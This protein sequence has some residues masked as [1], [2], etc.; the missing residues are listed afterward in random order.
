MHDLRPESFLVVFA[1]SNI[2]YVC[3]LNNVVLQYNANNSV[4]YISTNTTTTVEVKLFFLPLSLSHSLGA[5]KMYCAL[6]DTH[7]TH[8]IYIHNIC[9]YTIIYWPI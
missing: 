7:Y 2:Y 5:L 3:S 1:A 6:I 9:I 8:I 4:M